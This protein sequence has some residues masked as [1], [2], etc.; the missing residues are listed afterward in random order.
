MPAETA[1]SLE[2]LTDPSSGLSYVDGLFAVFRAASRRTALVERAGQPVGTAL[3]VGTDLLLTAAHVLDA[4][5][6]PDPGAALANMTAVFDFR[7]AAG[8]SPVET[9]IAI[10]V[11]RF[12]AG[13]LPSVNETVARHL[14]WEAPGDRLDFALL[15][16]AHPLP[17]AAE[18]GYFSL[19]PASYGFSATGILYIFQHPL[20]APQMVSATAGAVTNASGTRVRYRAN[21]IRGSSGSPVIDIRGR[22]VAMHHFATGN[23]NQGVPSARIAMALAD[24]PYK[25]AVGSAADQSAVAG[26][27]RFPD[28]RHLEK[29]NRYQ[30]AAEVLQAL[31]AA[32]DSVAAG[33][34]ATRL[35]KAG[36]FEEAARIRD[37]LPHGRDAVRAAVPLVRPAA[38]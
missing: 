31:A 13:S 17:D 22:L 2:A 28:Y 26:P 12:L 23:Q 3:L 36:R 35:H 24:G 8:T 38:G 9:G 21:T 16:L 29:L 10:R 27:P 33:E 5:I 34:L 1:P 37:A 11:T 15:R 19:D 18:R 14:D 32:G 30:E 25:D 20:G 4:R 6:L 7:P